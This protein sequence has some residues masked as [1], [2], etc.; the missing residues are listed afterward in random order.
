MCVHIDY[1]NIYIYTIYEYCRK[2]LNLFI[3]ALET[4]R[5]VN[6]FVSALETGRKVSSLEKFTKLIRS[7]LFSCW[8]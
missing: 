5:K 8:T 1:V 7:E 4:G 2:I 6:L 3:S